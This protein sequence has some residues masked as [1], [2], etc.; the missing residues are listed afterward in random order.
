ML[1]FLAVMLFIFMLFRGD[2]N[3]EL[4]IRLLDGDG[5]FGL[6]VEHVSSQ[7][8][9]LAVEHH[10]QVRIVVADRDQGTPMRPLLGVMVVVPPVVVVI[11]VVFRVVA[12]SAGGCAAGLLSL[13]W[14]GRFTGTPGQEEQA[15]RDRKISQGS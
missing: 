8:A 11:V 3:P 4:Q 15:R 7:F 1:L 9:R 14:R 2:R 6:A 10:F 5:L 12:T 13:V